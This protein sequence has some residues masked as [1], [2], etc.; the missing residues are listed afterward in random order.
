MAGCRCFKFPFLSSEPES[1]PRDV[2]VVDV[3]ATEIR[4]KW[5]PP[6]K[7]NGIIVAY[8]VLYENMDTLFMKNTSTT[9]IVL[10]NLKPYTLYNVSVRS[11]TRLGHGHQLS[12]SLCVRTAETGKLGVF[13]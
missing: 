12:S 4:L 6:E 5:S 10:R 3:T 7:P 11:Y 8:E 2:E 13:V 9:N 1:S